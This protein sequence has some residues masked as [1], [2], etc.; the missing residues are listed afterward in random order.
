MNKTYTVQVSHGAQ[1]GTAGWQDG[2]EYDKLEQARESIA[3]MISELHER[4]DRGEE[5]EDAWMKLHD[6]AIK[7]EV[8]DVL[9]FDEHAW[10]II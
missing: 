2:V 8:G 6:R 5:F 7:A 10:R 3:G 4:E 9:E 1:A